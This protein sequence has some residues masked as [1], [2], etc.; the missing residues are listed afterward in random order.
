MTEGDGAAVQAGYGALTLDR[1]VLFSHLVPRTQRGYTVVVD[2]DTSLATVFEMWFSGYEDNREV[3]RQVSY[4][5]VEQAGARCADGAARHHQPHRGQGVLLEAGHR[6][7]DA[8]VT[9]P[10]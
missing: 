1:V 2:Q 8:R 4:G 9:T 3:Q 10:R 5:Y 6:R 7:R